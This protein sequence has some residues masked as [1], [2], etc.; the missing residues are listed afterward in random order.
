MNFLS[1]SV[2]ICA[3]GV[4]TGQWCLSLKSASEKLIRSDAE[5]RDWARRGMRSVHRIERE[6]RALEAME[7]LCTAA[8]PLAPPALEALRRTARTLALAQDFEWRSLRAEVAAKNA[9]HRHQLAGARRG[10]ARFCTPGNFSWDSPTLFVLRA[11]EAG[12]IVRR[13]TD[14]VFWNFEHPLVR[15]RLE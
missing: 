3:L 9:Q 10:V 6:N 1:F 14:G 11:R 4:V 12:M 7:A 5:M 8:I 13:R 15:R 2:V